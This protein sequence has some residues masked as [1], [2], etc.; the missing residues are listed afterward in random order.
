LVVA[1]K[2][3]KI[4]PDLPMDREIEALETLHHPCLLPFLG[5]GINAAG[6][7]SDL[8][9]VTELITPGSLYHLLNVGDPR[10]RDATIQS[11][12]VLGIVSGMR[13]LHGRSPPVMH[14]DLKPANILVD[15]EMQVQ[16]CD[17]GS[18]K[19]FAGD[20]TQTGGTGSPAYCAPEVYEDSGHYGPEI[21][22]FSFGLTWYEI[23]T[24][25]RVLKGSTMLKCYREANSHNR[26][27]V[28]DCLNPE[29]SEIFGR[30]WSPDAGD[31]PTFAAI[32]T[33]LEAVAW[34]VVSGANTK[35]LGAYARV[36]YPAE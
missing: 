8:L 35:R 14:R 15:E 19:P 6:I 34:E 10:L 21:D 27:S 33:A 29:L 2:E 1:V 31:R 5:E 28:P 3:V 9:L 26:P 16:I 32:Q 4:S 24:G 22:V 20:V 13:Y 12:L 23:L 25:E 30:C 18:A 17:F 7:G 11:K 36:I